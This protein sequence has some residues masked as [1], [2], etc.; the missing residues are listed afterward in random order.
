M[1]TIKIL[2]KKGTLIEHRVE[3]TVDTIHIMLSGAMD[4][5]GLTP[6]YLKLT[7]EETHNP[8]IIQSRYIYYVE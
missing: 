4:E 6:H 8:I 1:A 7:S 3:E 2:D 5:R